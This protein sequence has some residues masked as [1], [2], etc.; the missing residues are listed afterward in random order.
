MFSKQISAGI[1]F[2]KFDK[3]DVSITGKDCDK[4]K[5]ISSFASSG[6]RDFLQ[7]NV[8][9]SG[10]TKP[11]PIQKYAIPII[12][13]K[14]DLMG[15]AQTGSGKTAAF[16]LP[17]LNSIMADNSDMTP[18]QPQCLIMAPTRELAIQ[19]FEEARKFAIKSWVKIQIA[20]GGTASKQQGENVGRGC[21]ILVA[22]PG[23]LM[24]FVNKTIVTFES[25]K[26]L[27]LDEADRKSN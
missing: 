19:I 11:T 14:R 25:L 10:Y 5:P 26:F 8:K 12:M 16:I 15:C 3:I 4:I 6:L 7:D 22:T 21:H 20:Y 23:R 24:D 27:V 1:N 18:G 2:D 13:A 9:R 17:I